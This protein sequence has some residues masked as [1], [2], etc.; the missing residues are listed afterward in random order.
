MLIKNAERAGDLLRMHD[1]R[2][3]LFG[4]HLFTPGAWD[5][6]LYLYTAGIAKPAQ[7]IR[8][9]LGLH[10]DPASRW[11]AALESEGLV[12]RDGPSALRLTDRARHDMELA[13]ASG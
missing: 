7:A 12:E 11:I 13:L 8:E 2:N 1:E 9:A 4:G 10:A 3:R 5:I 6:L